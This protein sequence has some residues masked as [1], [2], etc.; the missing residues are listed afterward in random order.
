M[1]LEGQDEEFLYTSN[2]QRHQRHQNSKPNTYHCVD[3]I[4]FSEQKLR[5]PQTFPLCVL[6]NVCNSS[7]RQGIHLQSST[8][9]IS[10]G[11]HTNRRQRGVRH[12]LDLDKTQLHRPCALQ[13]Q[14]KHKRSPAKHGDCPVVVHP[15]NQTPGNRVPNNY[16]GQVANETGLWHHDGCEYQRLERREADGQ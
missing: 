13:A 11:Y 5:I 2:D 14:D 7:S 3:M 15:M 6:Y 9:T 8:S 4:Q 16:P 1:H 12:W 10:G